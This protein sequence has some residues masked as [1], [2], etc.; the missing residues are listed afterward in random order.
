MTAASLFTVTLSVHCSA[1][2]QLFSF[3]EM[4]KYCF[5]TPF[6]QGLSST[7]SFS[8]NASSA[9]AHNIIVFFSLI[10]SVADTDPDTQDPFVFV[11]PP[12]SGSLSTTY[13]SGSFYHQ[14]KLVRKTLILTVFCHF[15]NFLSLKNYVKVASKSNKPK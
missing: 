10:T 5:V 4:R 1:F 6:P 11:G 2:P 14:A 3:P 12:E 9:V 7:N 13:G 15:D 8:D